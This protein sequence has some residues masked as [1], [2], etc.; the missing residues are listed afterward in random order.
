MVPGGHH[1]SLPQACHHY[2]TGPY[3]PPFSPRGESATTTVL[4]KAQEKGDGTEA[5][6]QD[7]KHG[8]HNFAKSLVKL[9]MFGTL[10]KSMGKWE[11]KMREHKTPVE[12]CLT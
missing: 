11:Q 7:C 2:N 4:A 9:G 12:L 6:D 5:T 1:W 3:T 8:I 10:S